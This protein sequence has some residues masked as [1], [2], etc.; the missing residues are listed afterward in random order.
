MI[1]TYKWLND[2]VDLKDY[3]PKQVA[4]TFT[5]IGYEVDEMRELYKGMER[6]VIGKITKITRHPNADKLQI[7]QINIGQKKPVQIITAATNVFEGAIVPA[8]L[9]GAELP[10]GKIIKTSNMRGE[11][12]QGM[13]CAGEELC[14]DDNVYPGAM[15]DG[16]MIIKEQDVKDIPLGTN[17]SVLLGMDD[18][19]YDLSVLAN[20]PDCQSVKGLAKELAAALN[21]PL[22][23]ASFKY[24]AQKLDIPLSLEVKDED[25]PYFLCCV[26]K[27]VKLGPS[28]MW[29]QQRLKLIGLKPKNNIV[30]ITNYVLWELGQPLHAYD[31]EKING[32]SIIVR[33]AKKGEKLIA[34]DDKEYQLTPNITVICDAKG[35]IGLAGIKGGA[36]YSVNDNTKTIVLES[37]TFKRE[38]IRKTSR[39]IGLRTDAS[40]RYERG[41]TPVSCVAGLDR[42]LALIEQLKIGKISN[43]MISNT[44]VDTKGKSISFSIDYIKKLLGIEIPEMD[45]IRIL[46]NLGITATIKGR[47][48]NCLTPAIRTDID[49]PNDIIEELIRYYG[50]DKLNSTALETTSF[51]KGGNSQKQSLRNTVIDSMMLT[52]AHQIFSYSFVSPKQLDKLLIPQD[53]VLRNYMQVKNPLSLDYSIM[54]TQLIGSLL[55]IVNYNL[56]H[57]NTN[58]ALFEVANTYDNPTDTT[59]LPQ[60]HTTL[61]YI[62]VKEGSNFFTTKSIVEMLAQNLGL[63][64]NYK[65][66][67]ISYLHPNISADIIWANKVIGHIGK[68][69][70]KV[71]KNFD[72]NKD[73]YYF[74]LNLDI[75]PQ[76]K[77]KKIKALP[78]YPASVRDMAVVVADNIASGD[79]LNVI[80]KTAGDT[81]ESVELFDVYKGAPLKENQKSIAWKLTFRKQDTTITQQEVNDLFNKVLATLKTQFGAELR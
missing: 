59:A 23:D 68:V 18:V 44:S 60:E 55:E 6:V 15:V 10:N 5:S 73:C 51:V 65:V 48:L 56:M 47:K 21:L 63:T 14:I 19:I 61:A 1:V 74:D 72:I 32:Q 24:K 62:D 53:S 75:V 67:N 79:M 29:M 20:R 2:F 81:C 39:S 37:A 30:D 4:Q 12:S 52:G 34:L 8:A 13:L 33:K 11:E 35:P 22:K 54:R 76:K 57:K 64:L 45:I 36:E 17:I 43:E 77:T 70:P 38:S 27:D 78:K 42:A 16:I 50:L 31:Y 69:N 46:G 66:A 9:D 40:A 80:K 58:F 3:T 28:P 71:I 25:C 26:V 7:C 41:V 49:G